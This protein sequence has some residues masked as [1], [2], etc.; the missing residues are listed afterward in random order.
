MLKEYNLE[1][2]PVSENLPGVCVYGVKV[3]KFFL[4]AGVP[5][6]KVDCFWEQSSLC[7][8]SSTHLSVNTCDSG[9]KL[10]DSM[11][12]VIFLDGTIRV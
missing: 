12:S 2:H 10:Q 7:L 8:S 6:S 4:K 9:C 5:L 1:V 11:M 3:D